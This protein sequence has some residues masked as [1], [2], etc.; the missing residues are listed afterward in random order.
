[1]EVSLQNF[2]AI[3]GFWVILAPV[4]GPALVAQVGVHPLPVRTLPVPASTPWA[5][6]SLGRFKTSFLELLYSQAQACPD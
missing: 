2:L 6:G 5:P 3:W 1:M 4:T